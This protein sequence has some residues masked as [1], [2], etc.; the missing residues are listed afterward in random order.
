MPNHFHIIFTN[1][2]GRDIEQVDAMVNDE[3]YSLLSLSGHV[4]QGRFKSFIIQEDV[5]LLTALRLWMGVCEV[6][7]G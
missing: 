6:M 5:S 3:P 2:S 1:S 7:F 4:W